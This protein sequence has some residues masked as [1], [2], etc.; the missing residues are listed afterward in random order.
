ML[1]LNLKATESCPENI[2]SYELKTLPYTVSLLDLI[3]PDQSI[4]TFDKESRLS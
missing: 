1:R 3:V 4:S 2:V